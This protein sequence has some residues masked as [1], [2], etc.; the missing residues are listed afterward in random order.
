[1][2]PHSG[3]FCGG[4]GVE[5]E[6]RGGVGQVGKQEGYFWQRDQQ[7]LQGGKICVALEKVVL[8]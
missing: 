1:M 3:M 5:T 8:L 4:G 6:P 2:S 7:K